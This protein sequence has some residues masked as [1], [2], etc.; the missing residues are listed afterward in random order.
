M[1]LES[2]FNRQDQEVPLTASL[3]MALGGALG[4]DLGH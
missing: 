2:S 3:A 4:Y 1:S